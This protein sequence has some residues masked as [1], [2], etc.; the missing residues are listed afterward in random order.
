MCVGGG[1]VRGV[2]QHDSTSS[3]E[4]GESQERSRQWCCGVIWSTLTKSIVCLK[5]SAH[6]APDRATGLSRR[7]I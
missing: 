7:D 4:T 5:S 6:R 1:G 3:R 2:K